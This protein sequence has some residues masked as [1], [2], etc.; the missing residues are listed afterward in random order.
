MGEVQANCKAERDVG[1]YDPGRR[2]V[3][4]VAHCAAGNRPAVD[5]HG[6]EFLVCSIIN[7][8]LHTLVL[9]KQLI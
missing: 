1:G 3:N 2:F 8:C 4:C 7:S 5:Q 9:R 6:I